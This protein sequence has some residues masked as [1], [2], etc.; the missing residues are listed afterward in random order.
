MSSSPACVHWSTD[1]FHHGFVAVSC[2]LPLSLEAGCWCNQRASGAWTW[3]PMHG[4][5]QSFVVV[6]S[7]VLPLQQFISVL[8]PANIWQLT[9]FGWSISYEVCYAFVTIWPNRLV[10][11]EGTD[12]NPSNCNDPLVS[13]LADLWMYAL[14]SIGCWSC[15]RLLDNQKVTWLLILS[16]IGWPNRLLN[17]LSRTCS[18]VVDNHEVTWPLFVW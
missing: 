6:L 8:T 7:L 11:H 5:R 9:Y 3:M 4:K 16:Q 10:C 17:I 13:T 18:M 12:W 15:H 2:Q 1:A 14:P